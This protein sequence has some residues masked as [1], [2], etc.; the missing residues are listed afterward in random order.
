MS[1]QAKFGAFGILALMLFACGSYPGSPADTGM[2]FLEALQAGDFSGAAELSTD[3]TAG[4]VLFLE[5]MVAARLETLE[6]LEFPIP[7]PGEEIV[8][9]SEQEAG[10]IVSLRY[11]SGGRVFALRA[12]EINNKWK[13]EMPRESW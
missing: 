6:D 8:L 13:I 10:D 3:N 12:T 7:P 2:Q 4:I 9:I 1:I 5:K 11:S